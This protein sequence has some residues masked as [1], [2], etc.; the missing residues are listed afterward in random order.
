MKLFIDA[1]P[2][3]FRRIQK[4]Y[5]F[6]DYS[7]DELAE[8]F[9]LELNKT[10]FTFEGRA[11]GDDVQK[12]VRDIIKANTFEQQRSRMNAGIVTQMMQLAKEQL[13]SRLDLDADDLETSI[14]NYT[15]KDLEKAVGILKSNWQKYESLADE[16]K[17][18]PTMVAPP[19]TTLTTTLKLPDES[20]GQSNP[21]ATTILGT[22]PT[23]SKLAQYG[24]DDLGKI[25][26]LVDKY[27]GDMERVLVHLSGT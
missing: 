23:S 5:T 3:L 12:A 9:C 15:K 11:A 10:G 4:Q 21:A 6:N 2:G 8:I 25:H 18:L 20:S 19:T 7:S 13:D 26:S 24:F 1:N 22:L 14:C 27:N 16:V 17:A